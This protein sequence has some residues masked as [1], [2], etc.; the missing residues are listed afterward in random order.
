MKRYQND[1]T[2]QGCSRAKF[3]AFSPILHVFRSFSGPNFL[4]ACGTL[5]VL[6]ERLGLGFGEQ[7][8]LQGCEAAP[9]LHRGN[10]PER[11]KSGHGNRKRGKV[12]FGFKTLKPMIGTAT[13]I[14]ALEM[15]GLLR[16][17]FLVP[18]IFNGKAGPSSFSVFWLIARRSC[19]KM[20]KNARLTGLMKDTLL[21]CWEN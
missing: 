8:V 9:L 19:S 7:R 15:S 17:V 4:T 5:F 13:S 20:R 2:S 14:Y 1:T 16:A 12:Y 6:P 18:S 21:C 10:G 3:T 11:I